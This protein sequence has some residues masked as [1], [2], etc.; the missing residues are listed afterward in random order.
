[1]GW[2]ALKSTV[3]VGLAILMQNLP[4]RPTEMQ[5]RSTLDL[6]P[7][8]HQ[9]GQPFIFRSLTSKT[10]KAH[11]CKPTS[12]GFMVCSGAPSNDNESRGSEFGPA[13][14]V[15]NPEPRVSFPNPDTTQ[16]PRPFTKQIQFYTCQESIS[17]LSCSVLGSFGFELKTSISPVTR[18]LI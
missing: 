17:R 15:L 3:V 9:T 7:D 4:L 14:A 18:K 13:P 16:N 5:Q 10:S 2:Q 11:P 1:M 8:P 6:N 12:S